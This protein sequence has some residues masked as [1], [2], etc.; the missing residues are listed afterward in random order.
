MRRDHDGGPVA[1]DARQHVAGVVAGR[2][3]AARL[4]Q[5][6]HRDRTRLLRERRSGDRAQREGVADEVVEHGKAQRALPPRYAADSSLGAAIRVIAASLF[7]ASSAAT[8][9][10][11]ASVG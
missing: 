1:A 4:E 3:E 2:L 9:Y 8:L 7:V 11:S 10:D 6:G 5:L